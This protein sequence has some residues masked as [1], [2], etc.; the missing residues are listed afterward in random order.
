MYFKNKSKKL[1]AKSIITINA[2]SD[3][4][5]IFKGKSFKRLKRLSYN[6]ANFLTSYL[7]T[8]DMITTKVTISTSIADVDIQSA[9]EIKIYEE[10]GLDE[11]KHYIISSMEIH[12]NEEEK[13]F[14]IFVV[15]PNILDKNYESIQAK[16][17]FI[18]LI[19]P[20]PLLFKTLYT[21]KI[22]NPTNIEGFLYFTEQDCFITFYKNGEYLYTKSLEYSLE[23]LYD[24]YCGLVGERIDE[25]KFFN[26]L[27]SAKAASSKNTTGE[28]NKGFVDVFSEYHEGLSSIFNEIF[29]SINDVVVYTTRAFHL[30]GIDHLYIGSTK[31]SIVGLD[32]YAEKH[33]EI[34][35][36]AFNFDYKIKTGETYT[37]QL[38]YLMLLNASEYLEDSSDHINVTMYPKPPSFTK[39]ASGQFII[40]TATAVAIGSA[41]PL[42][43]LFGSYA[44]DAKSMVLSPKNDQLREKANRYKEIIRKKQSTIENLDKKI[45]TLSKTYNVKSKTLGNIHTKKV[46]YRLKSDIF[47]TIASELDK[48]EVKIDELKSEENTVYMS[49]IGKD[50]RKLT[51]LIKYITEKHF[52]E[53]NAINI[54]K[55][56]KDL[57]SEYYRGILKVELR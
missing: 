26:L 46:H 49:L 38:Q 45:N 7:N 35:A 24:K 31:G 4:Y 32:K 19:T 51:E 22:L 53:I 18:D 41:W 28:Y 33:L 48:Y 36:S 29:N 56:E 54:R 21:N 6:K 10:L 20:A 9:L 3:Q 52:H 50:E 17:K 57:E 13:E 23:Y 43:Y 42:G 44:L 1:N 14:Q 15:D 30:K 39:R 55:I 2:Y 27:T 11:A 16:T 25:K 34:N 47:Y 40:A 37:D 8:K 12:H 5:Y